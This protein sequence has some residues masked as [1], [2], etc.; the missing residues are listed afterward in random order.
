[1]IDN[2]HEIEI[3]VHVPK[4]PGDFDGPEGIAR[5]IDGAPYVSSGDG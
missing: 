4:G 5:A 1:M 3:Y 2:Q